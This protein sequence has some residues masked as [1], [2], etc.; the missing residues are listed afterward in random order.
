MSDKTETVP[1][2]IM[3]GFQ[4]T[5]VSEEGELVT[6]TYE[7]GQ[8]VELDSEIARVQEHSNRL[9]IIRADPAALPIAPEA[10]VAAQPVTETPAATE[11]VP[12]VP[13]ETPAAS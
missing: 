8:E 9:R 10:E 6:T 4:L 11:P 1:V 2:K 12:E 13:S 7:P 5:H 3:F